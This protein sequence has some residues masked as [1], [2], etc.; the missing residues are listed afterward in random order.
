MRYSSNYF[1]VVLRESGDF[2]GQIG[3]LDVNLEFREDGGVSFAAQ[4]W[5]L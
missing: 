4:A 5:E 3:N 2:G 1:S